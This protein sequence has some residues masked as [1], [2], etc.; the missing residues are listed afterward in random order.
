MINTF[1]Y[2]VSTLPAIN[3]LKSIKNDAIFSLEINN[4][5]DIQKFN[6]QEIYSNPINLSNT[7]FFSIYFNISIESESIVNTVAIKKDLLQLFFHIRFKKINNKP[8]IF[9]NQK[10][11]ENELL[12]SFLTDITSFSILNGFE[13]VEL[14]YLEKES[15]IIHPKSLYI[16]PFENQKILGD[17]YFHLLRSNFYTANIFSISNISEEC[18]IDIN[19]TLLDTEKKLM[20]EFASQYNFMNSFYQLTQKIELLENELKH[21]KNDLKN[22]KIYLNFF[23]SQDEA[24]KIYEFYSNEYEILP[25]WYKRVGHIIKV[26]T[27]KRTFRSLFDNNVKKYKN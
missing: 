5:E 11:D 24:L 16:Y 7:C 3:V 10:D 12:N 26:L 20:I 21:T 18:L 1:N 22:Q 25:L 8:V 27:M 2:I 4:I 17:N 19:K 23:K 15:T 13:G 14:I 6:F 9:F